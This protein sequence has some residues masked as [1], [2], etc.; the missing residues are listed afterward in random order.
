MKNTF[1][2]L[3]ASSILFL[4]PKSELAIPAEKQT[5]MKVS[6]ITSPL[7][8]KIIEILKMQVK[9][10]QQYSDIVQKISSAKIYH[11]LY[12]DTKTNESVYKLDSLIGVQK[13]VA[14]A[15]KT[16]FCYKTTN[17]SF[18][19]KEEFAGASYSYNGKATDLQW[20]ITKD[21]KI[22]GKYNCQK[23][24]LKGSPDISVW[25]TTA[26]PVSNGPEYLYGLPGLVL[27]TDSN[28]EQMSVNKISFSNDRDKFKEII[29]EVSNSIK[30]DKLISLNDV[31]KA[32][33]NFLI[34]AENKLKK[35][36][37]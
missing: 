21:K 23:A 35:S 33:T 14:L 20:E 31:F 3:V 17:N 28:F 36:T 15:V 27:E 6:Y 16:A 26:I 37:N 7:S 32:K 8:A 2:S 25:F 10:P 4:H 22:I 9:D 5:L 29:S 18:F 19:G 34:M 24:F 11:T 12:I 13:G 30:K 1:F